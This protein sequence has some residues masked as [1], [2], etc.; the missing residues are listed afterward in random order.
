MSSNERS[1]IALAITEK[2]G[3]TPSRTNYTLLQQQ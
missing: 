3:T 2:V 1:S